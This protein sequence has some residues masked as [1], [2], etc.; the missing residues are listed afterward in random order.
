MNLV[1]VVVIT[2]NRSDKVSQC[3][4]ALQK[5]TWKNME[6]VAVI[7]GSTDRTAET[8]ASGKFNDLSLKVINKPNEG[9]SL[10][11]NRGAKEASGDIV[12]F[13]DDDMIP[14]P[15]CVEEHVKVVGDTKGMVSVGTQE[16][17]PA[18]ISSDFD[19]FRL[20]LTHK[21]DSALE[22]GNH[23]DY[24][25]AANF[26]ISREAFLK[27][28]GFD[29]E[30]EHAEDLDF[31]LRASKIGMKV[32]YNPKARAWHDN[33]IDCRTYVKKQR[34]Y[35]KGCVKLMSIYPQYSAAVYSP[36][37]VK[38]MIYSIVSR[39]SLVSMIDSGIFQFLPE[40]L[41]Y[42]LYDVVIT[43]LSK[44]YPVRYV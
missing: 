6:V 2:Y 35:Y 26:C 33:K 10:S 38:R 25:T 43:G 27:L 19:R 13:F 40:S 7:D 5:Q 4:A 14:Y 44:V 16:E 36:G 21:W 42:K 11:R 18:A 37:F 24:L 8:L 32:I 3:L 9:R 28:N 34:Q 23:S 41:R 1:S 15:E 22:S 29:K 20:H 30:T 12:I 31:A 17:Y 39:R